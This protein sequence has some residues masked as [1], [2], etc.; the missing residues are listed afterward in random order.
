MIHGIPVPGTP[1]QHAA[2][3]ELC[4]SYFLGECLF[5]PGTHEQPPDDGDT[6]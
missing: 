1:I 2:G 3:T 6:G 5:V 4:T